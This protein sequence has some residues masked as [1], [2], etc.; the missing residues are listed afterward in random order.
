MNNGTNN[1]AQEIFHESQNQRKT[2]IIDDMRRMYEWM[3]SKSHLIEENGEHLEKQEDMDEEQLLDCT[4]PHISI[5]G[6]PSDHTTLLF[7]KGGWLK[8]EAVTQ[9]LTEKYKFEEESIYPTSRL[10]IQ[11]INGIKD[12]EKEEKKQ[13]A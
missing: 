9:L 13:D 3:F 6:L 2:D 4:R 12:M 10:T 11:E 7:Y 1:N 5:P 8:D